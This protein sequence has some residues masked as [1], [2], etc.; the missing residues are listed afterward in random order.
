MCSTNVTTCTSSTTAIS[1]AEACFLNPTCNGAAVDSAGECV[2]V[3]KG[4]TEGFWG[5]GGCKAV[6]SKVTTRRTPGLEADW[7]G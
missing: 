1:M 3:R 7:T 4:D 5:G 6:A 2:R